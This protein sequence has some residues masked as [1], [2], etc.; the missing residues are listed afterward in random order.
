MKYYNLNENEFHLVCDFLNG[1]LLLENKFY[2]EKHWS[3]IDIN[4]RPYWQQE[5]FYDILD[6]FE[7]RGLDK[8]HQ[9]DKDEIAEKLFII[10]NTKGF[11]DLLRDVDVFWRKKMPL[12]STSSN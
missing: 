11:T 12:D 3:K 1:N 6:S 8:I 4:I 7:Y 9:V 5:L 10:V 2:P